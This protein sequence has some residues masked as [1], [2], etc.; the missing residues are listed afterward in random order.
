VVAD[1]GQTYPKLTRSYSTGFLLQGD[2]VNEAHSASEEKKETNIGGHLSERLIVLS[3][4]ARR[5]DH[6]ASLSEHSRSSDRSGDMVVKTVE[7][8]VE[9]VSPRLLQS[10][11]QGNIE[12]CISDEK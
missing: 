4:L 5:Y 10:K 8:A 1:Y 7:V 9:V 3:S 6:S 12:P 11:S 2:S